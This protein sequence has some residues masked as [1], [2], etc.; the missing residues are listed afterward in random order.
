MLKDSHSYSGAYRL[1]P[2]ALAAVLALLTYVIG[3]RRKRILNRRPLPNR[4]TPRREVGLIGISV[5]VV[6]IVT[7][8][9]LPV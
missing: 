7:A 6:I 8:L 4:I 3:V 1:V 2:S 5:L 9:V